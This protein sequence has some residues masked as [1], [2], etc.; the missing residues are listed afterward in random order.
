MERVLYSEI[1]CYIYTL[2]YV[3]RG[4]LSSNVESL[5]I[6]ALN[7]PKS[8][9]SD[10]CSKMIVK[11]Y[12]HCQLALLQIESTK[13]ILGSGVEESK[14]DLQ[15]EIKSV[16]KEYITILG[17]FAAIVLAFVG[18]ITFSTSVLN[19]IAN[20]SIY[21]TLLVSLVIGLVLV[22]V[23]FGL[24]YYIN[25]IVKTKSNISPLIISNVV[26]IL[27]IALILC[28]W[29]DGKVEFRNQK[30]SNEI[31]QQVGDNESIN[32]KNNME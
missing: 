23:L 7:N 24:F 12:D 26:I 9:I 27:M 28:F 32:E 17:I 15:R 11:I 8:D 22:N 10:S 13:D 20:A 5:F 29:Y 1:T 31:S 2:G 18:G 6:Y 19:N 21:R 3:E 4:T 25:S 14:I 16:E 30:I